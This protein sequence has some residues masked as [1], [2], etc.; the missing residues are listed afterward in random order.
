MRFA[1]T[2]FFLRFLGIFPVFRRFPGRAFVNTI[3]TG[4]LDLDVWTEQVY[5]NLNIHMAGL[6]LAL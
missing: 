4:G 3:V 5:F 6:C 1:I 2:T